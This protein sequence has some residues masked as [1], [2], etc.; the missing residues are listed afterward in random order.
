MDLARPE[1]L[2]LLFSYATWIGIQHIAYIAHQNLPLCKY[3]TLLMA[4]VPQVV[5]EERLQRKST[6]GRR[7]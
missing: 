2:L 1:A 4:I 7:N 3:P 6:F 5:Q